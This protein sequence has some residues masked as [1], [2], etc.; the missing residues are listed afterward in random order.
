M[1]ELGFGGFEVA[2]LVFG[3]EF[4]ELA[5]CR[6]TLIPIGPVNPIYCFP[7]EIPH[8]RVK[9]Y[10]AIFWTRMRLVNRDYNHNR[11]KVS[12]QNPVFYYHRANIPRL[13]P[14]L[15]LRH[16]TLSRSVSVRPA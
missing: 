12:W 15:K 6:I 11:A 3:N 7:R 9:I 10:L 14:H 16:I 8:F 4:F 13:L 1:D 5:V 2:V